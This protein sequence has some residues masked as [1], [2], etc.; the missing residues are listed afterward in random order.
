MTS[1]KYNFQLSSLSSKT[2]SMYQQGGSQ[3]I[4][5]L[6]RSRYTIAHDC[7]WCDKML[8]ICEYLR[9]HIHTGT[10]LV[11]M[12]TYT[13]W[14]MFVDKRYICRN[15]HPYKQAAD[16][17]VFSICVWRWYAWRD[18]CTYNLNVNNVLWWRMGMWVGVAGM[19]NDCDTKKWYKNYSKNRFCFQK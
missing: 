11:C 9:T 12:F 6:S 18:V 2:F 15:T 8:N 3:F 13:Q 1:F 10:H 16:A 17:Y 4:Y 5:T 14:E 7:S 19:I